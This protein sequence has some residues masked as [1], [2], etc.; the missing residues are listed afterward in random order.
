MHQPLGFGGGQSSDRDAGPH[1]DNFSD[2][3][4]VNQRL[5]RALIVFPG[6]FKLAQFVREFGF[7]VPKLGSELIL[8]LGYSLVFF[9]LDA[10]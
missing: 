2:I 5:F 3:F 4:F 7:P 9:L 10:L 8:S 1:A 6:L